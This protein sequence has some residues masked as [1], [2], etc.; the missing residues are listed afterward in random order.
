MLISIF[1]VAVGVLAVTYFSTP[2][3]DKIPAVDVIATNQSRLINLYHAGG[4]A[5][6]ADRLQILVDGTVRPFTGFG[7]DNNWSLGETLTYTASASDPMPSRVDVVYNQSASVGTGSYLLAS[8]ILGSQTNTGQDV[9]LYTITASAGTGGTI[10]PSGVITLPAGASQSFTI[11]N[12]SGYLLTDV[13]VD[14]SSIGPQATY[15]FSS[16]SS[17]HTIVATIVP[18]GVSTYWINVTAGPGGTI[19]PGN[20]TVTSGANKTYTLSPNPG[21]L[22]GSVVVNGTPVIPVPLSTYNFANVT[23]NQTLAATFA[24][25]MSPGCIANYYSD[26]AWTVPVSTNI[27]PRIHFADPTSLPTYTSDVSS[28]PGVYTNGQQ[29]QISVNFTGFILI[30]QTD[31]YTFYLTSD[32]GSWLYIDGNLV[33][34]NGNEQSAHLV[35]NT[36][37]LTPGYHSFFVKYFQDPGQAVV[38]LNYSSPNITQTANIPYYHTP[39][40]VPTASFTATPL[41]GN[42][43]LNVQ[44]NDTSL[45]ATTWIWN[46]GDGSPASYL[47]NPN[48]TYSSIGTYNV[49]LTAANSFG[50][51]MAT[52]NNYITVGSYIPGFMATYYYGQTWTTPAGMRTDPEIRYSDNA[53]QPGQPSDEVN[54]AIPMT[55]GTT[56]FSVTWDGYLLITAADSYTFYLTSD[57]G[58]YMWV[59]GTELINNGGLHAATTVTGTETLAPGYHHIVVN[60]YQNQGYAVARLQYTNTTI[61][62]PTQVT[63]V[64]HVAVV[65]PPVAGLSAAPLAGNA[66]LPVSFTD[67]STNTPT[68]WSWN[69]GDG[70]ATNSTVQNPVHSYAAAGS[71]N[72]S[73]TATNVGGSGSITKTNYVNVSPALSVVSFNGTPIS[74]SIPLVVNFTDTSTN[75]PKSWLW[76]FGDGDNTNSTVQNPVHKYA[77]AGIYSVSLTV[78]NAGGI[79]SSTRTGYIFANPTITASAGS[80]GTISP[81]GS[82]VV[83]YGTN[84]SFTITPNTGYSINTVTVDGVSQGTI[85]PYTFT[86]VTAAHTISATFTINTFTIAASAGSGGTI[87]PSGSVVVS[88]GT[89]QSFTITSNTGYSISTVTVDGISQGPITSY[90][91][92]NVT[93]IHTISATF[94][95]NTYTITPTAGTGG[96][97]SPS[98]VQT[99]NYGG[100]QTFAIAPNTGYSISTVTVDGVSQGLI[101]SYTFTNVTAIH[102][103]SAT[104]A[105]NTYTITP[106]AGTGGTISPSTVQTVNYGATPTFTFTPNIGYYLSS[107][108]VDGVSVTP[109]GNSYTFPAVTANHNLLATFAINTYTI[110]PTAGTGGTISPS[111]VQTVNYGATP[112]FTFTPNIGYYLSSVTV[113]GVSVTPSGNSYTFPA[114]TANHNLLATFA[115]YTYTITPSVSG[116]NGAISPSTVQTVNYGATPTF[117]FTPNTGYVVNAVTVDGTAVTPSGNTYTFPAVTANHAIQVTFKWAA[118]TVT[119]ILP[120]NGKHNKAVSITNI[121]GTNFHTGATVKFS[122]DAAGTL[123]VMTLSS[124][125]V[126]SSTQISGTL[127]IPNGQSQ[128]T[129]YVW[130]TNTDLQSGHSATAIFTVN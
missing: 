129:Y 65:Y 92:T 27:A 128:T 100:S 126:V 60:M 50:S 109:S 48:H 41:S 40:T 18:G 62:T 106:T 88:Y 121:G 119:S 39:I 37:Q 102:T 87:S 116:G 125:T 115:V 118:P 33:I 46:F 53:S 123:N 28:W 94:A 17:D 11:T 105:I 81:S 78:T 31:A 54:W 85:T 97:I 9:T 104:F 7:S 69:F 113:D 120:V 38:Y 23:T 83:S 73:L 82:V 58:S 63:N 71:Y 114:V 19:S 124:P 91:F 99:V 57:D 98:T 130:V 5:L 15:T 14:G 103:I 34:N 3:P 12:S 112:T 24:S 26:M 6:S 8:L 89:N 84:Q 70:D 59:D 56:N 10:T 30:N 61:T 35:S 4:D 2:H 43:P 72:V 51:S 55:G 108:T 79:N 107:V 93:A 22:I 101:T 127:N 66:P 117:T 44:F 122:T 45:D 111:T 29:T 96:T 20:L 13:L 36:L 74:G 86:N 16:V 68:S 52:Y 90:T 110:T 77:S 80:G 1:V 75:S 42:A 25:N 64:W 49:T 21:Y 95:I 76:I 47:E 67:A 32:D